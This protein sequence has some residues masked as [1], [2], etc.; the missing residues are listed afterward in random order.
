MISAKLIS[1]E[2]YTKEAFSGYCVFLVSAELW[3]F[4]GGEFSISTIDFKP[5]SSSRLEK[6]PTDRWRRHHYMRDGT[7]APAGSSGQSRNR[8][9]HVM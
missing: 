1:P 2:Y 5:F 3:Q 7:R 6:Q 9:C 4:F 8:L